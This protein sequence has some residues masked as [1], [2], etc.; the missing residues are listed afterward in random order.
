MITWYTKHE[1]EIVHKLSF[2]ILGRPFCNV[3]HYQ[4]TSL[5]LKNPPKQQKPSKLK[6]PQL[7]ERC[8]TTEENRGVH[9]LIA[10][11]LCASILCGLSALL[12]APQKFAYYY[13]CWHEALVFPA[14][15]RWKRSLSSLGKLHQSFCQFKFLLSLCKSCFSR[16]KLSNWTS[17]TALSEYPSDTTAHQHLQS[18][19]LLKV[20][21][22]FC[23]FSAHPVCKTAPV[24]LL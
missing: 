24:P 4:P 13:F 9:L 10:L 19:L 5:F 1:V 2:K 11:F 16:Q 14:A 22:R 8:R 21:L 20:I 18:F 7:C 3:W 23:I 6:E 12:C 15:M 17:L